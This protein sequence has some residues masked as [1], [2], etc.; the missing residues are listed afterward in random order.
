M[1]GQ[2]LPPRHS[3]CWGTAFIVQCPTWKDAKHTC[4]ERRR[5]PR[6]QGP[7]SQTQCQ[8]LGD[9]AQPQPAPP[10]PAQPPGN[11]KSACGQLSNWH[12]EG[13]SWWHWAVLLL[14]CLS[15]QVIC[16]VHPWLVAVSPDAVLGT[17]CG[18]TGFGDARGT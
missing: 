3:G 6:P 11:P 16:K 13:D 8:E 14:P 2:D 12:T 18:Q 5:V 15:P 7:L 1:G 4:Q 17:P 10:P 9:K